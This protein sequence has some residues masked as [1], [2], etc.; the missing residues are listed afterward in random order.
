M[1][2]RHRHTYYKIPT[3]E[4]PYENPPYLVLRPP[5][6]LPAKSIEIPSIALVVER[7]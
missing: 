4:F 1:A 5:D 3:Y 2:L 7:L 6:R